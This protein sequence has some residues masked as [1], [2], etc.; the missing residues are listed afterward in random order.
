MMA[1]VKREED[2]IRNSVIKKHFSRYYESVE[3]LPP[4]RLESRE[5]GVIT[6][7]GM[8]WRHHGFAD[9]G[10]LEA[11]LRRHVPFHVYHSSTYYERP[12]AR[13]MDEK[14][15][16]GADL[17]FDLDAD[18]IEGANKMSQ[19]EM[20]AAVKVEF[21]K[22]VDS[23]LLGDFGFDVSDIQIVFSGG[24]GY[25]AHVR[26]DRVLKLD[27]HERREIVDF[28]TATGLDYNRL[29]WTKA[30][31]S[32]IYQGHKTIKKIKYL[33]KP[34]GGGWRGKVG[35]AAYEIL[36]ELENSDKEHVLERLSSHKGI[37]DKLAEEI[38]ED[39]FAGEPGNRGVD[40]LRRE[41]TGF[42]KEQYLTNFLNFIV[43]ESK[44]NISGE[45]DEPVTSDIKRLIRLPGSLHGKSCLVVMKLDREQ[46]DDFEPLRDAFWEGFSDTP[47]KLMGIKDLK[48][49]LKDEEFQVRKGEAVELP[50]FAALFF[51]CQKFSE[52]LIS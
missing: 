44:V 22:L 36:D 37:G 34:D 21:I 28:I 51:L 1:R 47:V 42:S 10:E 6:E 45:T 49:R 26:N 4:K 16:L 38:W 17:V 7:R 24:R 8:M 43:E 9:L 23:Y 40:I 31:D 29:V 52:V 20:F 39:L 18:H 30:Y 25:H 5:F 32:S 12:S 15:W 33:P 3:V 35:R 41:R 11:F 13:T 19:E 50:E 27:S 46:L 2:N 48:I 14:G